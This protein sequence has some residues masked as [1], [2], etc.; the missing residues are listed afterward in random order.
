MNNRTIE[1]AA[2]LPTYDVKDLVL[3]R[4]EDEPRDIVCRVVGYDRTGE[5]LR[6]RLEDPLY[7]TTYFATFAGLAPHIEVDLSDFELHD[8]GERGTTALGEEDWDHIA[9]G[10]F[11]GCFD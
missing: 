8:Y 10:A 7:G 1:L 6:Y 3:F 9:S 4:P 11:R 2:A 5:E